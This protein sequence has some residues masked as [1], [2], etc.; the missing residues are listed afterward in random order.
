MFYFY[1]ELLTTNLFLYLKALFVG[2][3][4]DLIVSSY[5]SLPILFT[6]YLSYI[7]WNSNIYKKLFTI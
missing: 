6:I 5:L 4:L 1:D 7:G 2:I 3:R